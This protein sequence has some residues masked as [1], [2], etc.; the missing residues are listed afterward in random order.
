LAVVF[1]L[2]WL[3]V[4][5]NRIAEGTAHYLGS[6]GSWALATALLWVIPL[7]L[8]RSERAFF[9]G[10]WAACCLTPA[11]LLAASG[12]AAS[13]FSPPDS[14]VRVSPS[15]AFWTSLVWCYAGTL[16][17]SP[18]TAWSRWGSVPLLG[19]LLTGLFFGWF[20]GLSLIKEYSAQSSVFWDDVA[21]HL[22]LSGTAVAVG[23]ALGVAIG[24]GS[25]RLA[26]FRQAAFFFLNLVQT[27]PSLA[28]FGLLIVPLSL[29]GWGGIGPTPALIALSLYASFPIARST[30]TALNNLDRAVLDAGKGLG[31]SGLQLLVRV[32]VPLALRPVLDGV[33]TA[34]VQAV[35]NTVIA[36]LIG[37]GGLGSLIFFGLGQYAPDLIL[38]GTLPVVILALGL[39]AVW[40]SLLTFVPGRRQ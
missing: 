34:S 17:L 29:L 25:S 7:T 14:F 19:V 26:R 35:G 39:D 8:F 15:W 36:A 33:R 2:P 23:T 37:A 20:S 18:K 3:Q 24:W 27:L 12:F 13:D 4:R 6:A 10:I 38:L 31:M 30:L 22:S 40:A 21:R 16:V 32:Q 28:F 11:L 9:R 1:G 5:P